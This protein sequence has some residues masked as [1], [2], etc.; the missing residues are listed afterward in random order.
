MTYALP[1]K[2]GQMPRVYTRYSQISGVHSIHRNP[3]GSLAS[4]CARQFPW[5]PPGCPLSRLPR[6]FVFEPQEVGVDHSI[7]RCFRRSML[8]GW[9]QYSR[10]SYQHRQVWLQHRLMFLA[11]VMAID[12]EG[13]CTL[14][15]HLRL[16]LH[17]RPDVAAEWS[18][19]EVAQKCLQLCPPLHPRDPRG[20]RDYFAEETR[21]QPVFGVHAKSVFI[22]GWSFNCVSGFGPARRPETAPGPTTLWGNGWPVKPHGGSFGSSDLERYRPPAVRPGCVP[23]RPSQRAVHHLATTF[24]QPHGPAVTPPTKPAKLNGPITPPARPSGPG[25]LPPNHVV[26]PNGP[27]IPPAAPQYRR[28]RHL[29]GRRT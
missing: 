3:S 2:P 29:G 12:I 21:G 28:C 13:F 7:N 27:T 1:V 8:C 6:K 11:S 15:N 16:I 9:D 10:R 4:R 23:V 20:G 5:P 24:G 22:E 17:N 18:A 19:E 26:R 14:A 25:I